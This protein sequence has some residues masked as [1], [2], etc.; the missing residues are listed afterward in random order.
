MGDSYAA[1]TMRPTLTE[2]LRGLYPAVRK[3][4][5]RRIYAIADWWA[6]YLTE[7]YG[8]ARNARAHCVRRQVATARTGAALRNHIW[9][10][11]AQR[12][13]SEATGSK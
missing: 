3:E 7:K 13:K 12:L 9:G 4:R 2:L 8:T 10:Q 1:P 11:V 5:R 6:L